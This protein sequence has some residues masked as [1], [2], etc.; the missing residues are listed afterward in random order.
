MWGVLWVVEALAQLVAVVATPLEP[1]PLNFRAIELNNFDYG[2]NG[3]G[4][5]ELEGIDNW[6]NDLYALGDGLGCLYITIECVACRSQ[7][8][9][10]FGCN[11]SRRPCI[12]V[13]G[14]RRDA[15]HLGGQHP[16]RFLGIFPLSDEYC[17]SPLTWPH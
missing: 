10:R 17:L 8:G 7:H 16:S 4:G 14:P 11:T 9:D 3:H 15:S 12:R 5:G 13:T 2:V 1:A 6:A